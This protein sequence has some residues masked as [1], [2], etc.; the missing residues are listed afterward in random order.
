MNFC[1]TCGEK[2]DAAHDVCPHCGTVF[3]DVPAPI[4]EPVMPLPVMPLPQQAATPKFH[5][6]GFVLGILSICIPW[7][8]F[9]IGLVGLPLACI[10][11]RKASIV[12]NIIGLSLW[13]LLVF[14][15]LFFTLWLSTHM[16]HWW[17]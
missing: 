5:T 4:T 14:V 13:V 17:W 1:T 3:A 15:L 8:G 12:L 11:K 16:W 9:I 2:R 10:S 6:A 7:Y